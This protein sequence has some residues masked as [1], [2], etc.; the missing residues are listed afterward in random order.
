MKAT[1]GTKLGV[2]FGVVIALLGISA[3][4]A[5][6]NLSLI[7]SSLSELLDGAVV[8]VRR[9]DLLLT[10]VTNHPGARSTQAC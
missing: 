3:A 6:Y 7:Q 1:I 9:C 10:A 5:Y 2:G 4:T 8:T